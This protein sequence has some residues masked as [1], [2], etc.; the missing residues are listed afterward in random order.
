M[1]YLKKYG[2]I[3]K[4]Q[5]KAL[6]KHSK[7]GVI[8]D[9]RFYILFNRISVI[10]GQWVGDNERLSD[11][12]PDLQLKRSPPEAGLEPGTIRSTGQ[13]VTLNKLTD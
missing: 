11:V 3:L 8:D 4:F 1:S 7:E 12:E 9:L 2:K 6:R 13:P 10:S 5:M